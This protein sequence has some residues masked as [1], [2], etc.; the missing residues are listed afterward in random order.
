MIKPI[1]G[2]V[3]ADVPLRILETAV[4]KSAS[5]PST[6]FL[7]ISTE[8]G[9]LRLAISIEAAKDLQIDLSQLFGEE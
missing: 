2:Y 9:V 7:E 3:R 6:G 8:D 1:Q 4:H 5:D